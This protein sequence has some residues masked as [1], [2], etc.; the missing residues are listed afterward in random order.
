MSAVIQSFSGTHMFKPDCALASIE[1]DWIDQGNFTE[2]ELRRLARVHVGRL[3]DH[4]TNGR[5]PRCADALDP[6]RTAGSR[7]TLCRCIPICPACG[8]DEAFQ[9]SLGRPMSRIWEWPI[10]KGARTRR[11]IK[12]EQHATAEVALIARDNLI[13]S[14]GSSPIKLREHPGGWAEYGMDDEAGR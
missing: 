7:T 10:G 6:E 11:K 4:L 1:L 13:T 8:E 5:C 12:I 2:A 3:A 9:P 14:D